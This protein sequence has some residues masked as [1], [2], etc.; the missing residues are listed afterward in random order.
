MQANTRQT[1][2]IEMTIM[3]MLLIMIMVVVSG[4]GVNHDN[5]ENIGKLAE[6]DKSL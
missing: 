4:A 5:S 1:L 3:T 2:T 6:G